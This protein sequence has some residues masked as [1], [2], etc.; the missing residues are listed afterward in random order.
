MSQL[1][2]ADGSP[3][4]TQAETTR[5]IINSLDEH[6]ASNRL[7]AERHYT[8][9]KFSAGYNAGRRARG[10]LIGRPL[11]D[12]ELA[13]RT[14]EFNAAYRMGLMDASTSEQEAADAIHRSW[15]GFLLAVGAASYTERQI[16]ITGF[17]GATFGLEETPS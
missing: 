10:G 1:L 13:L 2:N 11:R 4:N 7:S 14:P 16:G 5:D 3:V 15:K 8:F 6:A 12:D 9:A 17:S